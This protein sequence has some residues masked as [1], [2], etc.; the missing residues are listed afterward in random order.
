MVEYLSYHEA[1]L[2][3]FLLKD[4]LIISFYSQFAKFS[5]TVTGI[6][7]ALIIFVFSCVVIVLS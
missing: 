6:F 2:F 7:Y 5:K 4:S 3:L 1:N